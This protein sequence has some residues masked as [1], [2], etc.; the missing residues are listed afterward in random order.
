MDKMDWELL[1]Q[2]YR[3]KAN[4]SMHV[5]EPQIIER[6]LHTYH[7]KKVGLERLYGTR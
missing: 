3:S 2:V 5:R 1:T 4:S 7:E 6:L